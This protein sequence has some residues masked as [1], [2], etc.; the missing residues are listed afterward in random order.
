MT[1]RRRSRSAAELR[2]PQ[3]TRSPREFVL[4]VCE[5][6][7]TE[8]LY[9]E[10]LRD[11][12]GIPR[13]N[14]E[15]VGHGAE[16]TSVVEEAAHRKKARAKEAEKSSVVEPYDEVWIVVD[17]ELKKD[18]PAWSGGWQRAKSLKLKIAWSNPCFEY[19]LL[20]HFENT[21]GAFNDKGS[22]RGSLRKHLPEF[23]KGFISFER[24]EAHLPLA[25]KNSKVIQKSQWQDTPDPVNCN[26]GTTVHQL[27]E[28]LF[29]IAGKSI[30]GLHSR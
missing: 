5:G 24:L 25:V 13:R 18:N 29:E 6:E 15:L 14:L 8:R 17:T 21:G 11:R 22:L 16:I 20:L 30:D 9:F 27:V 2:R 26:P 12:L 4:V 10:S 3:P 19:W 28:R 1:R 23:E 7:K